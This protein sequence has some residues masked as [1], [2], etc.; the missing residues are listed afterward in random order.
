LKLYLDGELVGSEPFAGSFSGF[1]NGTRNYLGQR[2]T[3]ADPPTNFKGAMDE[4]RVWKVARTGE[5]IRENIAKRLTGSEPGLAALWNFDDP[6]NPG[7]DSIAESPRWKL[8]GSARAG[9]R[10]FVAPSNVPATSQ[11]STQLAGISD[12]VLE[13]CGK[14]QLRGAADR[15]L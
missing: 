8:I 10:A 1:R 9:E 5:Q 4:V 13:T 7:R 3:L 14:G 2:V 12:H 6:A 11:D 15:S